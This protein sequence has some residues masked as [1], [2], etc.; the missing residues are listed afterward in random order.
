MKGGTIS[1]N[2]AY[3][4]LDWSI[5]SSGGG[6]YVSDSGTFLMQ[7]GSIS[8]ND[9]SGY[10]CSGG[11]VGVGIGG[12]FKK[13]PEVAGGNSGIIYGGDESGN[14]AN[15]K[16]LK[17]KSPYDSYSAGNAGDAVYHIPSLNTHKA[18]NTTADQTNQ[19][20]TAT[21]LGLSTSGGAPFGE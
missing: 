9:A 17:N 16:P 5:K 7:G 10:G 3:S 19:I 12:I 1:G 8:G 13:A 6:V 21:G 2:T 18:R 4:K 11:G 14:D 20:D 15:G